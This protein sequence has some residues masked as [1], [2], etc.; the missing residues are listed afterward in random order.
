MYAPAFQ[1][2][3]KASVIKKPAPLPLHPT[4]LKPSLSRRLPTPLKPEQE[5]I[6]TTSLQTAT[7]EAIHPISYRNPGPHSP[8]SQVTRNEPLSSVAFPDNAQ[9]TSNPCAIPNLRI[10]FQLRDALNTQ[11][12]LIRYQHIRRKYKLERCNSGGIDRNGTIFKPFLNQRVGLGC[13]GAKATS[14]WVTM[15]LKG[16]IYIEAR[17][18]H[19]G[20]CLY[21]GRS[22]TVLDCLGR[23]RR[24]LL[25][26]KT[27]LGK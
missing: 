4:T 18:C 9:C 15:G 25:I 24:F 8:T 21:E 10:S 11:N 1:N 6:H 12:L 20:M 7:S 16:E 17:F 19:H 5:H 13:N 23:G 22:F 14:E 27:I 3:P 2:I 26:E